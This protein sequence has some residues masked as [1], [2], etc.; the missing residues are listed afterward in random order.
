MLKS[1]RKRDFLLNRNVFKPKITKMVNDLVL[2]FD[3]TIL[4]PFKDIHVY[5]Y[6]HVRFILNEPKEMILAT[7]EKVQKGL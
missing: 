6:S 3:S 5:L 7:V 2:L 4:S 1:L